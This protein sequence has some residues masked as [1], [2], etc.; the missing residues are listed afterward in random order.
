MKH[1]I[2]FCLIVLTMLLTACSDSNGMMPTSGGR[3]YEVIVVGQDSD[4]CA[5]VVEQLSLPMHGLP[6][7]EPIFDVTYINSLPNQPTCRN[8]VTVD[9]NEEQ[10]RQV[11]IRYEQDVNAKPQIII[12]LLAPDIKKLR[13]SMERGNAGKELRRL[14]MSH[15]SAIT[16]RHI[17]EHPNKK[18]ERLIQERFG[19]RMPI[20]ADMQASK[21]ADGFLW[22]ARND[23]NDMHSICITTHE[24]IDSVLKAN[25]KGETDEMYMVRGA[26]DEER[27]LWEMKGDD[28]GGP[29]IMHTINRPDRRTPVANSTPE[30]PPTTI[31]A[32]V[33]A[34][35]K[36]KR[37][38]IRRLETIINSTEIIK[39]ENN[40]HN[41]KDTS[42]NSKQQTGYR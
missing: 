17:S 19:I 26:R 3:P 6:Q 24:N 40:I 32:F 31:F 16:R 30:Q 33:Y 34:P 36:K 35:G 29:Y 25:I 12:H 39:S 2:P 21:Q 7:E 41:G 28:M 22:I 8:L 10:Y 11:A 15:E 5:L 37:N 27:G 4:A 14:I 1:T 38:I 20:P 42:S 23:G 18:M 9:L 13:S